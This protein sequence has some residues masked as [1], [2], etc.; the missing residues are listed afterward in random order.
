[1]IRNEALA[2]REVTDVLLM[3]FSIC[4]GTDMNNEALVTTLGYALQRAATRMLQLDG[5]EIGVLTTPGGPAGQGKGSLLYD[6]VPGGAGHVRELLALGR[7]WLEEA[8]RVLK[9]HD[10]HDLRCK[11]ACLDCLLSF[12]T[13]SAS[14][15]GLL[16]RPRA[17]QTLANL[18]DGTTPI[19]EMPARRRS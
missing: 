9:G 4:L 7:D 19:F 14:F 12:D 17:L 8:R 2:A 6:N 15:R 16:D 18:L 13:Q 1:M 10:D 11:S 3:D 5:R